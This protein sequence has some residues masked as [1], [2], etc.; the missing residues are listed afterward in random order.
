MN[1]ILKGL[2][3]AAILFA[4][5]P[6]EAFGCAC[7]CGVYLVGTRYMMVTATGA[8]VF[9]QY[10]YLDQ[11]Q[12]WS[13]VHQASPELNSDRLLTTGFYTLGVQT[14]INREWGAMGSVQYWDR[15]REGIEEGGSAFTVRHG[16]FGDM[17]LMGMYTGFSEDMST[18][19]MFGLKL[20]T[21]PFSQSLL[22]RDTQ[23]GTGST[24]ALLSAYQMDQEQN[25]GWYIQG[26][27]A[28][29]LNERDGYKPGNEFNAAIGFH[30]DGL[31]SFVVPIASLV[32]SF[33]DRDSGPQADPDN[34]GYARIF[35][36][37]G[38]EVILGNAFHFDF[39]FGLP[40][41][42][43]TNGYQLVA[44]HLLN[45]TLSYQF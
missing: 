4:S 33:R 41:Y 17:K 25:W 7:G 16:A 26:S 6:P 12:N 27:L 15:S 13:G 31:S 39:E 22:D 14:M 23:I 18:G 24:D 1:S 28:Y 35:F 32:T 10:S 20:P 30:Y 34:T 29:P 3:C 8:R 40:L 44:P 5:L 37:P 42:T 19:L 21:G 36:S 45:S 38:V 2:I 9:L 43:N 11:N